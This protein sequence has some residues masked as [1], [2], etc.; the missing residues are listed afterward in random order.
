MAAYIGCLAGAA[1]KEDYLGAIGKAGFS[2]VKIIDESEFGVEYAANDPTVQNILRD[3]KLSPEDMKSMGR[4]I[5]S[6][7][8]SAVKG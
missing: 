1:L 3:E 4:A 7:K 2:E 8:V 5:R 6:V